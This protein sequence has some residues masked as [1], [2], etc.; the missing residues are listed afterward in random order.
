MPM[1]QMAGVLDDV[2]TVLYGIKDYFRSLDNE[3]GN[4]RNEKDVIIGYVEHI[5]NLLFIC[6]IIA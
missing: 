5:F 4:N 3:P 6:S 1:P 2:P